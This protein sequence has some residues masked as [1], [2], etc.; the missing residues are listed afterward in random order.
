MKKLFVNLSLMAVIICF[1]SVADALPYSWQVYNG[2]QYALTDWNSW[3]NAEAE[4]VAAGGHL[5]TI[6]DDSENTWLAET[7]NNAYAR[8]CS[9]ARWQAAAW[10]GYNYNPDSSR[11]EWISGDPVT[12][13]RHD[14]RSW[15]QG[16]THA[17]IH[18]SNHIFGGYNWNANPFHDI[19]YNYNFKGIIEVGTTPAPAP[20]PEPT[21]IFLLGSGFFGV[22]AFRMKFKKSY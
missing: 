13:Y 22:L 8:C 14:Y 12:Y 10:I 1:A 3:T 15:P 20:V 11:W 9:G 7:F 19:T 5:V 21:T 6:N 4:A 16:G 18:T 17:Y 2:H